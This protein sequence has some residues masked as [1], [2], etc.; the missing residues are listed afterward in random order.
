[1]AELNPDRLVGAVPTYYCYST[2]DPFYDQ[3]EAQV[4][5][6]FGGRDV[7]LRARVLGGWPHGFGAEGG[8]IEE[9]ADFMQQAFTAA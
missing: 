9:Y 2:T 5:V 6:F 7:T 3:F 4:E 8:W 1:M